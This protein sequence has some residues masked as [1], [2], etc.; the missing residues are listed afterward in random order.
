MAVGQSF[1]FFSNCF[2]LLDQCCLYFRLFPDEG[3]SGP[4]NIYSLWKSSVFCFARTT[5]L[6]WFPARC[7]NPLFIDSLDEV[8]WTGWRCREASSADAL[9]KIT[10]PFRLS[11]HT[12]GLLSGSTPTQMEGERWDNVVFLFVVRLY[13]CIFIFLHL[14]YW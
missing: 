1:A 5:C 14:L 3:V 12:I 10:K 6:C 4:H 2:L 7:P 8:C 9:D 11:K 13:L